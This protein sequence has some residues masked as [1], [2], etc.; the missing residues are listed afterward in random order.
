MRPHDFLKVCRTLPFEL[1]AVVLMF[2]V[3]VTI[4][5][6][7]ARHRENDKKVGEEITVITITNVE[8]VFI[9]HTKYQP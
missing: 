2:V 7:S 9:R 4:I 3:I 5:I 6:S 8:S 1:M